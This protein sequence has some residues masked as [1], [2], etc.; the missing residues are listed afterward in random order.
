MTDY[1]KYIPILLPTIFGY[2]MAMFCNVSKSSGVV[3]S[4]RPPPIVFS[5]VWILLYI[6]LGFSW[7]FSLNDKLNNDTINIF[8]LSLNLF[9]CLWIYFYSCKDDKKTG[10]YILIICIIFSL[11]CYTV[12]NLKSKLLIIPLIGWLLLATLPN[13]FEVDKLHN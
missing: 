8:Y 10:I 5:V 3:V 12:G 4:F 13:V 11:F 2:S 7:Y 6:M 9:L 1:L